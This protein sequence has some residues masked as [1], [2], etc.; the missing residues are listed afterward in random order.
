MDKDERQQSLINARRACDWLEG[1]AEDWRYEDWLQVKCLIAE[2]QRLDEKELRQAEAGREFGHLGAKHGS[3]G[4][5]PK[6]KPR[7]GKK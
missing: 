7:K 3:K 5:W 2:F 4:G 6:G 1:R